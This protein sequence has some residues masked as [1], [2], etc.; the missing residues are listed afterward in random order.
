MPSTLAILDAIRRSPAAAAL[1]GFIG[2]F[3]AIGLLGPST[4]FAESIFSFTA[5]VRK[6]GLSDQAFALVYAIKL[7][8]PV[9]L[10]LLTQIPRAHTAAWRVLCFIPV[11]LLLCAWYISDFVAAFVLS[12]FGPAHDPAFML[13]LNTIIMSWGTFWQS[14]TRAGLSKRNK[15]P[16]LA[17]AE[18]FGGILV[19]LSCVSAYQMISAALDAR[20][21]ADGRPYCVAIEGDRGYE[22]ISSILDL[23]PT[24]M[25]AKSSSYKQATPAF[26]HAVLIVQNDKIY[27]WSY[28]S[29]TFV[30][31]VAPSGKTKSACVPR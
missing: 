13:F 15:T 16:W 9:A 4:P 22:P 14:L 21:L 3:G 31:I 26:H 17:I 2:F 8:L 19:M 23:R 7:F 27:N 10:C 11:A 28:D 20:R 30:P 12:A 18:I 24:V 25:F 5:Y 6:M 29:R 1:V